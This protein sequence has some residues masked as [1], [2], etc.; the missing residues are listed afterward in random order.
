VTVWLGSAAD[1]KSS[2]AALAT[3]TFQLV[4]LPVRLKAPAAAA[5]DTM[6]RDIVML[7]ASNWRRVTGSAT[8]PDAEFS[9]MDT[10]DGIEGEKKSG[11]LPPA[12]VIVTL[13]RGL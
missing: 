7:R 8:K 12:T 4:P 1:S 13:S 2:R 10:L 5:G 3:L 11:T 9:S 6:A